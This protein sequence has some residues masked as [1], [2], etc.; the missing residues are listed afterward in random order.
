MAD[1]KISMSYVADLP[2]SYLKEND[3]TPLSYKYFVDD[4]ER[5]DDGFKSISAKEFYDMILAGKEPV[6]SQ[7]NASEYVELFEK[8]L[9]K[10]ID[11]YHIEFSSGLSGS[12]NSARI[13]VEELKEKYPKRKI[14]LVDS[15]C[16]SAGYGLMVH[17]AV[18][19]KK[20][21]KSIEEVYK[22]AEE[23]K[24]KLNH[25]FT[26]DD[27][28][29]LKRGGRLSGT[30]ATVGT[31]L[32]IKPV[33]NLDNEGHLIP[34]EK[35]RGR[36]KALQFLVEK[37]E[38][39]IVKPDGQDV[40]ISHSYCEEDAMY[41]KKLVEEKFPKIGSVMVSLIGPVIGSHT[42]VGTVGLYFM[43]NER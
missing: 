34:K 26:V 37:M 11:I 12:Y 7:I 27:L 6:T 36:K 16:A 22:F 17:Y 21:G 9:D 42:G 41:V 19:M 23:N 28:H 15:L 39:K 20:A 10:G 32:Q 18:K 43:G 38:E 8:Y 31:M 2:V 5:L 13:A 30:A 4:V 33:L 3:L 24:L 29:H 35:I 1:F 40:F 14:M 25:W